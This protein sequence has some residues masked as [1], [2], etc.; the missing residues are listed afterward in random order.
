MVTEENSSCINK[1]KGDN[2]CRLNRAEKY[3]TT[4]HV[5]ALSM[6]TWHLNH[7]LRDVLTRLG[8]PACSAA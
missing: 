6:D 2:C 5:E 3:P 4:G 1:W 7:V 8:S